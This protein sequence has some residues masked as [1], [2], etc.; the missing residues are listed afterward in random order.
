MSCAHVLALQ[1][2]N[3]IPPKLASPQLLRFINVIGCIFIAGTVHRLLLLTTKRNASQESTK[4]TNALNL[5][6]HAI[7][8]CF[9]PPL[10]FFYG[11][12]YTDVLSALSVLFAFQCHLQKRYSGICIFAGLLSVIFRQTNIF[13]T[14][15]FLGGLEFCRAIPKGRAGVEF[16]REPE[17]LDVIKGS[18]QNACSYDPPTSKANLEGLICSSTK[19]YNR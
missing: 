4:T 17:F 19:V 9:F 18:W 5:I 12:Y 6:H 3:L 13:W 11:L 10:F 8:I 15:L 14:S 1:A 7:N 2:V 16:S